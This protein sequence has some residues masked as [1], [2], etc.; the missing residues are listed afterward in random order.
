MVWEETWPPPR[1]IEV[2]NHY[3]DFYDTY[4]TDDS[5]QPRGLKESSRANQSGSEDSP[6]E[7]LG[8]DADVESEVSISLQKYLRLRLAGS[9][10]TFRRMDTGSRIVEAEVPFEH[11][12]L[13]SVFQVCRE[14]RAHALTNFILLEDS[15]IESYSFYLNPRHDLAWLSLDI[16]DDG[17]EEVSLLRG[18]YGNQL[19]CIRNMLVDEMEWDYWDGIKFC[20][21]FFGIFGGLN[22]VTI[23]LDDENLDDRPRRI[24]QTSDLHSRAKQLE[25]KDQAILQSGL[26]E[27]TLEY[28]GRDSFVYGG[29]QW[30][31]TSPCSDTR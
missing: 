11:C 31:P 30:S 28:V 1:V 27:G 9:L 22:S 25:E 19:A 24:R 20:E 15:K 17:F 18:T 12:P 2:T 7:D 23:L 5:E 3:S 16:S 21:T 26:F 14:S 13:P 10:S 4:E 29:L 8:Y 6:R